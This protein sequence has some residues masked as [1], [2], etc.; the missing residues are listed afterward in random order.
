MA[1]L[2]ADSKSKSF[3]VIRYLFR[4]RISV[5]IE[6]SEVY[7]QAALTFFRLAK[8]PYENPWTISAQAP[9]E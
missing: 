2:I 6:N 9:K 4:N 7:A 5:S 3:L 8:W 1:D